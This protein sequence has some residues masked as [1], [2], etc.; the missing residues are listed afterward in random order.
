MNLLF[1]LILILFAIGIV[2]LAI[3]TPNKPKSTI[4]TTISTD[5][6][7]DNIKSTKRCLC[8]YTE[9]CPSQEGICINLCIDGDDWDD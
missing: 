5:K 9:I 7:Q 1:A 3:N 8:G 6:T 2:I 4:I